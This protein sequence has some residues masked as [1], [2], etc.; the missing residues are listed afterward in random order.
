M[1]E[2]DEPGVLPGVAVDGVPEVAPGVDGAGEVDGDCANATPVSAASAIASA[3][4]R[5]ERV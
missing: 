3:E 5:S 1:P 2:P 4:R